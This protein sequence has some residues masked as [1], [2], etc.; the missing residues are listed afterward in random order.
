MALWDTQPPVGGL[1]LPWDLPGCS[2][3]A[4]GGLELNPGSGCWEKNQKIKTR[5][6]SQILDPNHAM[7]GCEILFCLRGFSSSSADPTPNPGKVWDSGKVCTDNSPA[8]QK[9]RRQKRHKCRNYLSSS[10][11]GEELQLPPPPPPL[12][13]A[14]EWII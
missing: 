14:W 3:G 9:K 11:L 5:I 12:L 1:E 10:A 13:A 6:K 2:A 4:G 7:P 8:G